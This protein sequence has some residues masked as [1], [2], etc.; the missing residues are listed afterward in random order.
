[1]TTI[2]I[3]KRD[4]AGVPGTSDL[5]NAAGGAEI[6]VNTYEKRIYTKNGSNA[7]VELGTNPSSI[8]SSNASITTLNASSA[9]ITTISATSA[10]ITTI[11]TSGLNLLALGVASANITTLTGGTS[12]MTSYTDSSGKLRA[13][14]SAGSSVTTAYTLSV[15]DI[16]EYVTVGASGSIVVPNDIFTSGDAITIYNDTTGNVTINCPI[17]TAYLNGTNADRASVTLS[18]RGLAT[19]L[20]I[21]PSLCVMSGA[22]V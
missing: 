19:V 18:T 4:T 9:N 20:F 15:N 21:N 2:L 8:S 6:A 17:T 16:G 10:T 3:K 13:I 22:L 14:P 1:M 5:T 11:S 12:V 7:V